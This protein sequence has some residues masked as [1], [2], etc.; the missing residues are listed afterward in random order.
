LTKE[1][2]EEQTRC[3]RAEC[4]MSRFATA[5]VFELTVVGTKLALTSCL[6]T[7]FSA[8]RGAALLVLVE[9][10]AQRNRGVR[11]SQSRHEPILN[12][13]LY[14]SLGHSTASLD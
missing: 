5:T 2:Q 12:D 11:N 8:S 13:V 4:S 1:Q 10:V 3:D 14:G 7:A 9:A 6:C